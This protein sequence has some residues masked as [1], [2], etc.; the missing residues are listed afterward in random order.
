[1]SMTIEQERNKTWA[2]LRAEAEAR[3]QVTYLAYNVTLG[4]TKA[5]AH[6]QRTKQP[7]AV[8]VRMRHGALEHFHI[9]LAV[10]AILNGGALQEVA[11]AAPA[12][13]LRSGAETRATL[14]GEK[15][16]RAK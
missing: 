4:D 1:M 9:D 8:P 5:L 12:V 15:R 10:A 7:Q 13:G 11:V 6:A 16:G 14:G 3:E 2:Q